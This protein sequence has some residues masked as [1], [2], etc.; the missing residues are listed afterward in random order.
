MRRAILLSLVLVTACSTEETTA[1]AGTD[2]GTTDSGSVDIGLVVDMSTDAGVVPDMTMDSGGA[3]D[4]AVDMNV[5]ADEGVDLGPP[6]DMGVWTCPAG[7][8]TLDAMVC[9]STDVTS[10]Y[11]ESVTTSVVEVEYREDGTC[12]LRFV[13]SNATCMK[14][15][16]QHLG[17]PTTTHVN[18]LSYGIT[19]CG[20]ASCTFDA[21]DTPCMTS[22]GAGT[23]M[24]E[25]VEI[26]SNTFQISTDAA[27]GYCARTGM[28]QTTRWVRLDTSMTLIRPVP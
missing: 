2:L 1:D 9:G 25:V 26:D 23:T 14:E 7:M 4:A 12:H 19:G 28:T 3:S 22:D 17:Y 5:L 27:Y 21:E 8:W 15:H 24:E 16:W 6:V 13:D 11:R 20:P 18:A 10:T